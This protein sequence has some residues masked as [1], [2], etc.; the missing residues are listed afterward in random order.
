[1]IDNNRKSIIVV[2]GGTSGSII[3][4]NLSDKFPVTVF[5]RGQNLNIPLIYRIPLLIGLLFIKENKYT[6]RIYIRL[7]K[8]RHVPFFLPNI[9]GGTS[10][11]NGCV[12]VLGSRTL[13]SKLFTRFGIS[14]V[15]FDASYNDLFTKRSVRHKIQIVEAVTSYI[16]NLFYY[17]LEKRGLKRGDVENANSP[18]YG[19]IWNT[20]GRIFRTSVLTLRP[21]N[22]CK[23]YS[24]TD[25]ECLVVDKGFN[26]IGVKAN[27]QIFFSDI[28]IL[29]A[30][31]FGSNSLLL[32]K[33]L[34]LSDHTYV[35][36]DL[37]AGKRIKDHTNLRVN[38]E[39]R[40]PL[41]S[42][43]EIS[44]SSFQKFVLLI[45]HILGYKTLMRGTGA[46]SA[47]HLDLD[48]DGEVDTRIQ[49]LNFSETGRMGS[50]GNLF[51]STHPGF[52][53]SI[54]LINPRSMGEISLNNDVVT[55]EPNYLSDIND[56]YML[57]KALKYVVELLNSEAFSMVVQRISQLDILKDDPENYITEN[58]YSGYHLIGGCA[59]LVDN[60]FRVAKLGELYICDASVMSEYTS[61]NIHSTV[62]ILSDIFSK[63][64]ANRLLLVD[65]A[66][67]NSK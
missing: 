17:S 43:N 21:F 40:L 66:L 50:S 11:I 16:D 28:I 67:T 27:N 55:C 51:S 6:R 63:K 47:A 25:V 33:A 15:D 54:T 29:S 2:G 46:T 24:S 3:A 4:K 65:V 42:L 61:S 19:P 37:S 60:D 26:V 1:M 44:S 49:M 13:W 41:G 5:D 62:A 30:G 38:V 52:S 12:H 8:N 39:A 23:V 48:E 64:L 57:K 32:K 14:P 31:V 20:A 45:K 58:S 10:V 22:K 9:L 36:L 59:H 53:I 18:A 56:I 35:D 34:R 7:H